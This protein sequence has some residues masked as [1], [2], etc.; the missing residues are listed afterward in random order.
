MYIEHFGLKIL[1][2]E[3]VPDPLFFFDQGDHARVHNRIKESL[4]AGRG[5]MIVTG[6][7][8]SGKTTLSQMIKSE[9]SRDIKLI[10]MAVPPEN[11][12]DLFLFIAQ[13][14]GL[15]PATSEKIF[16]I[17]DIKESLLKLN[18]EGS[19]CLLIID[20]SHLMSD[21]T[22]NGIRLLN[23]LEEGSTKLIQILLLGQEELTKIINKP[24]ME[25]FKQRIATLEI[26]GKMNAERSRQY[27]SHRIHVAGGDPSIF[28]DTGWE[29]LDL[30]FGSQGIPRLI[31]SLCDKSL[32][33][34]FERGKTAVDVY[35][36]Y[37]AAQGMGL[38]K[39][40]F[41]YIVALKSSE[42]N[43]QATFDRENVSKKEH[44]TLN[45]EPVHSFSNKSDETNKKIQEDTGQPVRKIFRTSFLESE[46]AQRILKKP[47]LLFFISAAVLILSVFFYCER[48][49]STDLISCLFK[50]IGF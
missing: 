30:A 47:I 44:E 41:H 3:N 25:P 32:N 29:A 9:F 20:E 19:K 17:R 46:I 35:D 45:K 11:S 48:S 8:G 6:P 40:I 27:I 36:V 15:K 31:N 22:I 28:A 38:S 13:E 7:I 33:G 18:S 37:E 39:E 26:I 42:R 4:K 1:P 50:L 43:K 5:L 12:G 10:W 34:A 2:F 23:N 24:E 14:L 16:V 21:D 49:G